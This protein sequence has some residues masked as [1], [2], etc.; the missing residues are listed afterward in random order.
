MSKTKPFSFNPNATAFFPSEALIRPPTKASTPSL[1]TLPTE[2]H[3]HLFS[4]LDLLSLCRLRATSRA[5]NYI[6]SYIGFKVHYDFTSPDIRQWP[7]SSGTWS[8]FD[9]TRYTYD[10]EMSWNDRSDCALWK[11]SVGVGER[12]E[13]RGIAPV[14]KLS[15][16]GKQLVWACGSQVVLGQYGDKGWSSFDRRGNAENRAV[17]VHDIAFRNGGNNGRSVGKRP[18]RRSNHPPNP[19]PPTTTSPSTPTH[20]YIGHTAP[21]KALFH[22]SP[23]LLVTTSYDRTIRLYSTDSSTSSHTPITPTVTYSLPD[24]AHERPYS[25]S[26]LPHHSLLALSNTQTRDHPTHSTP[27]LRLLNITPSTITHNTFLGGHTSSIYS[28]TLTTPHTLTSISYGGHILLHDVRTPSHPVLKFHDRDD[29]ALYSVASD[30]GGWRI[31]V[32]TAWHATGRVYDLRYGKGEL[33]T[34]FFKERCR[35][36]VYGVAM[37]GVRVFAAVEGEMRMVCAGWGG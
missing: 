9:R 2:L 27:P 31:V 26:H 21:V 36:P 18:W 32:G 25:L 17:D 16:D 6:A 10:V 7:L 3:I 13:G 12:W 35:S 23:S 20:T 22:I 14:V 1:L 30:A 15:Q 33:G 19:S 4:F 8:W 28:T 24:L 11:Q 29:Y 5:A 34:V 37:D